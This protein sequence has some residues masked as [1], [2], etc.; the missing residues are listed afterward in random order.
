MATMA[1]PF[2]RSFRAKL[3]FVAAAAVLAFAVLVVLALGLRDDGRQA[4][5]ATA[6]GV[7]L[8]G[9]PQDGA[10][11]G[12]ASAPVTLV[13]YADPQCP[14]CRL[15]TEEVFPAIVRE[16]VR[17]GRVKLEFRGYAFLGPDSVTA[18]RFL[19]AASLQD[20]LWQLQEALYRHQ[21][22]ENEGWVTDELVRRQAAEIAGLDV[23][24][25]F[26]DAS[27]DRIA[28]GVAEAAAQAEALGVPGTPTFF[29]Q[30]ADGEPYFIQPELD[31]EQFRAA[32]DDA[33]AG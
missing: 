21:G 23:E 6:Q 33:L 13:E 4:T 25:L 8:T 7:D 15:Y 32:L 28:R 24:R 11:L 22:G 17:P 10:V 29:V 12:D 27:S 18:T 19:L 5:P 9:I 16:Y 30:I 31:P 20:R 3:G 2:A 26:S 14:A 1:R